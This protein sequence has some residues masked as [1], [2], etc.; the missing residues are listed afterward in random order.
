MWQ[1]TLR[2]E[3]NSGTGGSE[4]GRFR[5]AEDD[6]VVNVIRKQKRRRLNAA[7]KTNV[8]PEPVTES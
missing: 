6:G 3:G 4:N 1:V 8:Q 7:L 5:S 2:T